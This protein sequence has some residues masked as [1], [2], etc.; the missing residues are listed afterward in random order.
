M[1]TLR[2][3]LFGIIGIALLILLSILYFSYTQVSRIDKY[4]VSIDIFPA[5]AEITIDGNKV[6]KGTIY[7]EP[8]TY[9]IEAHRE[10]FSKYSGTLGVDT[11]YTKPH[12]M[13]LEPI[14]EDAQKWFNEHRNDYARVRKLSEQ[15]VIESGK[16]FH[17]QNPIA[18]KLPDRAF[19]YTIGYRADPSDPSGNSIIIEIDAGETY[20]EAALNRIRQLGYDPTDFTINFR[21]YENPFPL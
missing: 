14:S 18:S 9:T 19:I 2:Y 20:R 5:N 11:V 8:G 6:N 16:H 1:N 21:D 13:S 10:G 7:L 17:E 4:A 3:K 15:A 12:I